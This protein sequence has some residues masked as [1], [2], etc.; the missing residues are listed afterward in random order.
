MTRTIAREWLLKLIFE[1]EFQKELTA[2]E[3]Y[4]SAREF[5]DFEDDDYVKEALFGILSRKEEL[6][7]EIGRHAHGW[8]VGRI[9]KL[10][11]SIM[12]I[13]VYEMKY[14]LDIPMS[15][16]MDVAVELAKK[17][18]NAETAPAFINGI[19]NAVSKTTG[20]TE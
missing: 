12:R 7:A 18:D 17:Y 16:S 11:L 6:D 9:S 20:R 5:E 19:V 15:V 10:S 4:E 2:E 3:I 8:S 13:C 1:A 14:M